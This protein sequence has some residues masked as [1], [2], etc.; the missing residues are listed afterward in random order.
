MNLSAPKREAVRLRQF[1]LSL[2]ITKTSWPPWRGMMDW[3][4]SSH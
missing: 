4:L 2:L 1:N 3:K